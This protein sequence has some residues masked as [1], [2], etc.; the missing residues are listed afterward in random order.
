MLP[1]AVVVRAT[2]V[3]RPTLLFQLL[4]TSTNRSQDVHQSVHKPW[5]SLSPWPILVR[6]LRVDVCMMSR[7]HE[8]TSYTTTSPKQCLEHEL[9]W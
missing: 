5:S 4:F 2:S 1:T 8:G 7:S 6:H 3:R 9:E